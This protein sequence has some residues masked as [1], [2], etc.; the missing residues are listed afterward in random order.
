MLASHGPGTASAIL[1]QR[2]CLFCAEGNRRSAV[3][4]AFCCSI[5]HVLERAVGGTSASSASA[6]ELGS[7]DV[8]VTPSWI[9]VAMRWSSQRR[10]L[11]L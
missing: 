2:S 1:F 7:A 8:S 11:R 3:S 9:N 5:D 6:R 4:K 10:R